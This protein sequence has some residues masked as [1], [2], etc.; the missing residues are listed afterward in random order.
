[1]ELADPMKGL[2]QIEMLL[3]HSNSNKIV[4]LVTPLLS[5]EM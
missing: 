4:Q 2:V 1:M 5:V 3:I